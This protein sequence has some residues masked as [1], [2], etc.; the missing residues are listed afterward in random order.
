MRTS[1]TRVLAAAVGRGA[2]EVQTGV[3]TSHVDV[4]VLGEVTH[5]ELGVVTANL[6]NFCCVKKYEGTVVL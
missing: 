5:C 4:V 3:Y 1:W 2:A 6:N